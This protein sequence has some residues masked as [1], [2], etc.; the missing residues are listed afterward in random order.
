LTGGFVPNVGMNGEMSGNSELSK[1]L[2]W[3]RLGDR[4]QPITTTCPRCGFP[5][6]ILVKV[7]IVKDEEG[8]PEKIIVEEV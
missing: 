5:V 1:I 6:T 2:K 7:R 3:L 8:K 4:I